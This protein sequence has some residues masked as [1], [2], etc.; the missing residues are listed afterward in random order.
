MTETTADVLAEV[1]G[2]VG[3]ITL[4]RPK[5]INALS[6]GMVRALL[7]QLLAWQHDDKVLAVA[8]RGS[9]KEGVFGHFCAAG[10]S[11]FCMRQAARA[12][13]S[14]RTSSPRNT[15]STT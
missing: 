12:T 15:P 5:A 2:Q 6:L 8:I 7:A 14:W 13:P 1:R 4:N 9:H 10:T 11:A 3:F